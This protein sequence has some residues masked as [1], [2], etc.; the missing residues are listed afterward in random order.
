MIATTP[1][2]HDERA[3]CFDARG[4]SQCVR[5]AAILGAL[6]ALKPGKVMRLTDDHDP[7]PL[8]SQLQQ[9]F[10]RTIAV[11]YVARDP[12]KVVID[13]AMTAD[14]EEKPDNCGCCGKCG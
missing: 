7:L 5:H 4:I 2:V 12:G 3:L 14:A 1:L 6:D 9:R 8:L 13:L 10:G 11:G